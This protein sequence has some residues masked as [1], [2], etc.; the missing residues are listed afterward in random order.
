[1]EPKGFGPNR[2]VDLLRSNERRL[3]IKK[4]TRTSIRVDMR[5]VVITGA[6][7]YVRIDAWS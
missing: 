4:A 1:M 3:P 2:T 5:A 6:V 7:A